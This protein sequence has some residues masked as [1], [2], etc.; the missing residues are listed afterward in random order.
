MHNKETNS[1]L[2]ETDIVDRLSV[3]SQKLKLV[4]PDQ[5]SQAHPS[6]SA[7]VL[8]D[9]LAAAESQCRGTAASGRDTSQGPG[10]SSAAFIWIL[11]NPRSNAFH[12]L[13]L[14]LPTA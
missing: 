13:F 2:T 11:Q 4:R 3:K 14:S 9:G 6:R 7:A 12:A 5:I 10:A 1:V 8:V